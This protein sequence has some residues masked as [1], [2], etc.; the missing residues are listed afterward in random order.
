MLQMFFLNTPCFRDFNMNRIAKGRIERA[1]LSAFSFFFNTVCVIGNTTVVHIFRTKYKKS[2]YRFFVLLLALF[3][4]LHG[5]CNCFRNERATSYTA[6]VLWWDISRLSNFLLRRKFCW[7]EDG[8]DSAVFSC[9]RYKKICTPF[10]TPFTIAQYS[11]FC[12]IAMIVSAILN[13]PSIF[14]FGKRDFNIENLNATRCDMLKKFDE[15][16]PP[17]LYFGFLNTVSLG[18]V[19]CYLYSKYFMNK[20]NKHRI[21]C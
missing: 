20:E 9:E 4:L 3:D 6:R 17:I 12:T 2:N 10:Q 19:I 1:P 14:V 11:R 13:L 18:V 7:Y 5:D 16:K 21:Y 8:I 15:T